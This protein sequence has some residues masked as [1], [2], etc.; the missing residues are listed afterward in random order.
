MNLEKACFADAFAQKFFAASVADQVERDAADSRAKRCHGNVEQHAMPILVDITGDNKIDRHSEKS[1]VRESDHKY[2][3]DAQY[4]DEAQNPRRVARQN[5]SDFLQ[6]EYSVYVMKNERVSA[7]Q[8]QNSP[9]QR[10]LR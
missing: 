7:W 6:A 3:P 9:G 1:A 5:V 2:A 8:I 4:L 10:A